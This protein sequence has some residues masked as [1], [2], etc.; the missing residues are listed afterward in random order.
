MPP[1]LTWRFRIAW[2]LRIAWLKNTR[3][4]RFISMECK[5]SM[6]GKV[7]TLT[8]PAA[9]TKYSAFRVQKA[10]KPG[11]P[12][13]DRARER[14]RRP[15][16]DQEEQG[17]TPRRNLQAQRTPAGLGVQQSAYVRGPFLIQGRIGRCPKQFSRRSRRLLV[18]L[19]HDRGPAEPHA[20]ATL[21]ERIGRPEQPGGPRGG[22]GLQRQPPE[23]VDRV[24]H[25]DDVAEFLLP[26]ERLPEHGLAV[27]F[28]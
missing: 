19:L 14:L 8:A 6:Q 3:V 1:E 9:V 12:A 18:S 27:D 4:E 15:S 23:H 7:S 24:R 17:S 21:P 16:K 20:P 25:P 26:V 11:S 13:S 10:R 2:S 5:A 28:P 22:A